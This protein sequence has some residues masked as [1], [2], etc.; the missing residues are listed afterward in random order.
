MRMSIHTKMMQNR[1]F[2]VQNKKNAKLCENLEIMRFYAKTLKL[3]DYR[4]IR[5]IA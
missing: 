5:I 2:F 3:C 1:K 4:I